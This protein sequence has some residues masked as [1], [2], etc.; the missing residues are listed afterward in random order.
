MKNYIEALSGI[1]Y[2]E[3]IRLKNSQGG[4]DNHGQGIRFTHYDRKR[5]FLYGLSRKWRADVF[6]GSELGNEIYQR[7]G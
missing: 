1:T 4:G 3:W 5:N 2:Y 7:T 6:A